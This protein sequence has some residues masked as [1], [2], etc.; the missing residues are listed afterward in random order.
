[1]TTVVR[2]LDHWRVKSVYC[3]LPLLGWGKTCLLVHCIVAWSRH[4]V[5][6]PERWSSIGSCHGN[7]APS[8][9]PLQAKVHAV[10]IQQKQSFSHYMYICYGIKYLNSEICWFSLFFS[11]LCLLF[12]VVWSHGYSQL[13]VI[14]GKC[15]HLCLMR[16]EIFTWTYVH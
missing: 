14:I 10:M 2:R 13:N 9:Q 12:L 11:G 3:V 4:N 6:A 1:M 7:Q 8:P 5:T 15:H 16:T